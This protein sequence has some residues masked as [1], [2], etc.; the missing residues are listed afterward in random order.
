MH[1]TVI[2]GGTIV[3]GTGAPA[4]VGD[5]A[6]DNGVITAVGGKAG[7]ARRD[8]KAEGRLVTPGW[9]D[10]HTHY[11][12]QAT[13]DSQ[14]APSSWHGATT[15]L[16][17]NCGV[18]FAPV[19]P[20]HHQALID[21]MEGVEDIPGIALA[22]GLKWDWQ[23]F[24]EYLDALERLPRTI[25]VGTQVAHHPLRVFVMGERAI[26][27]EMA[28][29]ADV[30]EMARL[31]EEAIRAGAFG[32]TTSRT[33]Q[34][35]TLAGELV[36]GRYA[37][38]EELIAIGD[39]LGRAGRGTFGMLSDFDDEA[40]EFGW[41]NTILERNKLPLWFLLTDR[42]YDPDRWRR[43]MDG[44]RAARSRGL[45][46]SAQV[47]GRPVGLILGLTTSLNPFALRE[48]FAA[49]ADLSPAEQLAR[50]RDPAVKREILG[51]EASPRLVDVLPP[52]SRQIATRWDRMYVL[53][54]PPNYEPP[55]ERSI[56]AMAKVAGQTP[57]EFCY[58]YLTGGDG[59]RMLYFPVTNY[60]H[61][62]LDVVH[63]M[64]TDPHTVLGLSDGGAHCGVIC[65]ASLNSFMLTHWVR[66][67]PRDRLPLEFA[68]KRQTSET[69]DFFGFTD[70]GRLQPGKK[71]DVNVIDFE[72]L[73]LHHP[74]MVYDLPAGGRRLI[75]KVDGYDMTMVSGM[76][77]FEKGEGTGAM[78]GKLVRAGR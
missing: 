38:H 55:P 43:L 28:T 73:R 37:E 57:E 25:D 1:D 63:E 20:A 9:V 42:S 21:L 56:A 10:V 60:V 5:V 70:R 64:V 71:A 52:L 74:Y 72:G 39:A 34:H 2:R 27:R 78:P 35:K 22:E 62:D 58:D 69:A 29:A 46:M 17:G 44:V 41:L 23:S 59:G 18:G 53:G 8:V 19:R 68:I 16:M 6:I 33:D 48:G 67:R 75:Q 65:D 49:L 7:P 66:D 47:A 50:L 61:G 12:G 14:L 24:P 51:Q 13:W 36:P 76:P 40:A 4:F 77:V 30:A 45:P 15:I 3:D 26:Q 54:D 11:D 31:T 32:F